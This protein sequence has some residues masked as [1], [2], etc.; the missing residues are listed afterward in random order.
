V[1]AAALTAV[2]VVKLLMELVFPPLPRVFVGLFPNNMEMF[3]VREVTVVL[4]SA[5]VGTVMLIVGR[6]VNRLMVRVL[7]HRLESQLSFRRQEIR[8]SHRQDNRLVLPPQPQ[9]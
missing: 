8:L 4:N 7:V 1:G 9:Q 6:D 3:P 5:I 2:V